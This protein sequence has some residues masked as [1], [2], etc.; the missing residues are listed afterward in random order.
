MTNILPK[1]AFI[2]VLSL[3]ACQPK[4]EREPAEVEERDETEQFKMNYEAIAEMIIERAM[5]EPGERVLLVAKP[6][7]FDSLT[8]LL[9]DKIT[10]AKATYLGT[11]S[12]TDETPQEW[13]TEF[14]K[15]ASDKAGNALGEYFGSVDL[16]IMLPGAD[17]THAP[18]AAMQHVLRSGHGRTIHF[19]WAGAYQM[20]GAVK[21]RTIEVDELYQ[22]AL[23][24]TDYKKL[25]QRHLM[26]EAAARKGRISIT[27]PS[28]T[29]IHFEIGERPVTK[30]DGDASKARSNAA[31][32]FIDREIEL[33]AGAVRVAPIEESVE[34]KIAFPDMVWRG[35]VVR[36]LT[37]EFKAGK[38]VKIDAT[39]GLAAVQSELKAAGPSASSFRELAIGFNP[40]LAIPEVGPQWIPYYGYGSG[41][42][43]LS[44]GDN[45][46]LGG[47]VGGKY[48]RWNFFT[49]ATVMIEDEVWIMDGEVVKPLD[50]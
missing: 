33:P 15:G 38:A 39:E 7:T 31:R 34:G 46:E 22:A 3:S 9:K 28:G 35:E 42:I 10:S 8:F 11:F 26:F 37:M 48:V 2:L 21:T 24:E 17:T 19:H 30:Q 16:G 44:L 32:N 12:V 50:N 23:L 14:T 1:I 4:N 47:K 41:V 27:T 18:Y 36:G 5:L 45:T 20:N 40:W 29:D 6:E 43:R 13:E 49:D 25:A